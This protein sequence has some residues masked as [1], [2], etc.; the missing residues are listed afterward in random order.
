MRVKRSRWRKRASVLR[1]ASLPG[2][3]AAVSA[4]H[5]ETPG[6]ATPGS[7]H[8]TPRIW[9]TRLRAR[10]ADPTLWLVIATAAPSLPDPVQQAAASARLLDILLERLRPRTAVGLA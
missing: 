2:A 8:P 3:V 1:V 5:T 4:D 6:S 10:F 7:A 9:S